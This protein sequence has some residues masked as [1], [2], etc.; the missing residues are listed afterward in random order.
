ME[1][2]AK[3]IDFVSVARD[4]DYALD[5][6]KT[7]VEKAFKWLGDPKRKDRILQNLCKTCYYIRNERIGGAAM[8]TQPCGVCEVPVTYSST[9]T[10][11][12]CA[13]CA[14]KQE[15]CKHCGADVRLR[16][17]RVFKIK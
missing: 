16:P 4:T 2:R 8:T 5:L 1:R 12:L 13:A 17:R 6:G 9:C 15:L 7:Y 14:K 3:R 10:D 11:A